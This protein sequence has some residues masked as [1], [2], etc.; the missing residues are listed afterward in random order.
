MKIHRFF[1]EEPIT[2]ARLT[3][4]DFGLLNQWRNV[5]RL[6]MGDRVNLLDNTEF[7]FECMIEQMEK[8]QA[9][10]S[11]SKKIH[12]PWQPAFD[13][14]L[15]QSVI[16]KDRFEWL[17]EKGTELGVNKFSPIISQRSV[18]QKINMERARKI[19]KES[20]EQSGRS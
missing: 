2:E 7:E 8:N 1:I 19:L 14:E 6:K 18:R 4:K 11:V 13:L 20:S 9:I 3:L 10:I 17:L 5:L 16:K 15:I 12:R